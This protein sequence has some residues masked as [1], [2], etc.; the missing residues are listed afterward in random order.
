MIFSRFLLNSSGFLTS[1]FLLRFRFWFSRLSNIRSTVF[2]SSSFNFPSLSLSNSLTSNSGEIA[3]S[4][5]RSPSRFICLPSG[6]LSRRICSSGEGSLSRLIFS[7]GEGSFSRFPS[8]SIRL[9][10]GLLSRCNCSSGDGSRSLSRFPSRCMFLPSA[11]CSF[12]QFSA[13]VGSISSVCAIAPRTYG[14]A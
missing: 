1:T 10:S 9:P 3:G 5:S 8:R 13:V 12:S 4:F 11:G 2:L 6:F 14:S 7:S